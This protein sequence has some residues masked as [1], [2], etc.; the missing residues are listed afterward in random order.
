MAERGSRR[1]DG[2]SGR[3]RGFDSNALPPTIVQAQFSGETTA[4]RAARARAGVGS[5]VGGRA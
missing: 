5:A 3:A 1:G 4:A 2:V